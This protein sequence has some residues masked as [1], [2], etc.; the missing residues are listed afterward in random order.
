MHC[1]MN[2]LALPVLELNRAKSSPEFSFRTGTES[3]DQ[4]FALYAAI[5]RVDVPNCPLWEPCG[6]RN[7]PP[8]HYQ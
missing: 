4:S 1:Q 6:K 2:T 5:E 3:A 7:Q 8:N